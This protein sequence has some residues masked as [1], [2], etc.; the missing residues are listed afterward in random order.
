[1]KNNNLAK[2]ILTTYKY[3]EAFA[4]SID[5]Q[6]NKRAEMSFFVSSNCENSVLE[7]ADKIVALSERKINYINFKIL[8]EEY[9]INLTESQAEIIIQR[10]IEGQDSQT[11]ADNLNI[12]IRTYYRKLGIAE[13]KLLLYLNDKGYSE[14]RLKQIIE[15]DPL[16][17]TAFQGVKSSG[18]I[19]E[20]KLQNV[21]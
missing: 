14:E 7:V 4:E 9:I 15:K 6:V 8:I 10:Y 17:Y 19:D 16:L 1:M 20:R 5:K 13:E 18:M 12:P 21:L 2:T 3:F 11:I